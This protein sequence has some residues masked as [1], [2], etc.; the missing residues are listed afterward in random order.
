MPYQRVPSQGQKLRGAL[1]QTELTVPSL[2]DMRD[3]CAKGSK[4]QTQEVARLGAFGAVG[5]HIR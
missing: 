2:A 5:P 3:D 4:Q 1:Y